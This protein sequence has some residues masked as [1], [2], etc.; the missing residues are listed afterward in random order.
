M[1]RTLP[2]PHEERHSL[3]LLL[4][5]A[6]LTL[7]LAATGAY[8]A[9]DRTLTPQEAEGYLRRAPVMDAGSQRV[10]NRAETAYHQLRSLRTVNDDGGLVS[11]ALLQRPRLYRLTQKLISGE[12]VASAV[13]DGKHYFEYREHSKQYLERDADVLRHLVLPV[14]VRLFFREQQSGNLLSGLDGKPTVR[15]YGYRYRGKVAVGG[16]PAERVDVSIM[17]RSPD[18]VWHTF[19]SERYFDPKSGLLIRAVN[20]GRTMVIRNEPNAKIAPAEFR[21]TPPAGAIKGLG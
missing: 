20:G 11:V 8:S 12:L 6:A 10:I 14:H 2:S 5:A 21:W 9:E 13:S 4:V 18:G 17:A 15:E 16:K 3:P 7:T 19:V 1:T